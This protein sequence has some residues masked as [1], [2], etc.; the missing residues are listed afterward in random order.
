M[1]NQDDR[2]I[3]LNE[4][5]KKLI[6]KENFKLYFTEKYSNGSFV[7]FQNMLINSE[8]FLYDIGKELFEIENQINSYQFV[9]ENKI[10]YNDLN[11]KRKIVNNNQKKEEYSKTSQNFSVI[12]RNI[13]RSNSNNISKQFSNDNKILKENNYLEPINF[14]KLLRNN[15]KTSVNL[16]KKPFNRFGNTNIII[17]KKKKV[18]EL[19]NKLVDRDYCDNNN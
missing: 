6:S 1:I 4:I 18:N 9:E 15:S 19:N 2:E 7:E 14:E 16:K 5:L 12:K 10:S 11:I 8:Q 3:L 17:D 13:V